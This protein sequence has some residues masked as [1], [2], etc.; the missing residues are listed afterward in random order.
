MT[1]IKKIGLSALAG[2]L[3]AFSANAAELSVNGGVELTYVDTGGNK[4]NEVTGNSYGANSS[5]T[6]SGSGDVGFGTVS[7]TRTLNDG[8]SGWGSSFQTL[9]MGDVGVFSFDSTA[10][11]LVGITANDDLMPTAYEEASTGVSTKGVTGVGSTNV[12]GYR[13]TFGMFSV[14]AGYSQNGTSQ[15]ESGSGGQ[16]NHGSTEDIYVSM[17]NVIEGLSV[18]AGFASNSSVNTSTTSKDTKENVVNV[19]Y[20]TGPVSVGY[21]MFES[22]K[23]TAATASRSGD[24]MAIAFNVNDSFKISYAVQDTTKDGISATAE[25]TEDVTGISAAYTSGAASVRVN[26]S[27][28]DNDNGVVGTDDETTEISLVLSF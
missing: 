9:D 15:A 24:H 16:A 28:A 6:L 21:R 23:G 1:N 11:A 10:G 12:I 7:M 8:N 2:S 27:K 26:H 25:V 13:N 3:V 18:G 4:G 5:V 19:V 22:N 20:S 14:S 17:N